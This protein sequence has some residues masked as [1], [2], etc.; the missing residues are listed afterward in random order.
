M[1]SYRSSGRGIQVPLLAIA[2]EFIRIHMFT[3]VHVYTCTRPQTP[4]VEIL[5]LGQNP[6]FGNPAYAPDFVVYYC[7]MGVYTSHNKAMPSLSCR[8]KVSRYSATYISDHLYRKT[9]HVLQLIYTS[10]IGY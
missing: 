4:A 9:T 5:Y 10:L 1:G 6:P 8:V 7:Y 3:R 2:N